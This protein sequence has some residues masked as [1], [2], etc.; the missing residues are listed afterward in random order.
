MD[1]IKAFKILQEVDYILKSL[2]IP[3]FF[4]AGTLLGCIRENDFIGHDED[5]DL[6]IFIGDLDDKLVKALQY[7][8]FSL[9]RVLGTKEQGLEYSFLKEGVQVDLFF[10]Y[11]EKNYVWH[12]SWYPYQGQMKLI[13][14]A[15]DYFAIQTT[16]FKGQ[17]F[18]I[19]NMPGHYLETVYGPTWREKDTKWHWALSPKNVKDTPWLTIPKTICLG[20]IVKNESHIIKETLEAV[21]PVIDC[22]VIVDT[23]ST[24]NTKEIIKETF[25]DIPG[26]IID[27]PWVN[28]GVNRSEV[29]AFCRDKADYFLTL[30]ADE[31]VQLDNF[32]KKLIADYYSV[33]VNDGYI[34]QF[35]VLFSNHLKWQSIGVTHEYWDCD[36]QP[37]A[38]RLHSLSI[39]H[40]CAGSRRPIKA[41]DDLEL[42]LK[43]IEQEPHN[44]RYMFYLAQTYKDRNEFDKA[45][46]WYKARIRQGGWKAEVFYSYYMIVVCAINLELSFGEISEAMF[47][48]YVFNPQSAEPLYEVLRYCRINQMYTMGYYLGRMAMKIPVPT[49]ASLFVRTCIYDYMI[50]DEL[51][52]CAYWIEHYAESL[53]LC[54]RILAEKKYPPHEHERLEKNREF[55]VA[56]LQEK[57]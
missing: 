45:I 11:K 9:D 44:S 36:R 57:K 52:I 31:I 40:K 20:M 18:P 5:I 1:K 39:I 4:M 24:D 33:T 7:K 8:G 2:K 14:Y 23:G 30:D 34:Y 6:G 51:S 49:N 55:C 38:E 22:W 35:P 43:G 25:K 42:L 28:F 54:N 41:N 12:G 13:K 32:N 17:D 50:M 15:F 10:Y 29:A 19:P 26:E 47:Q 21:K 3:Y 37:V 53:E 56:Q 46:Y 48:A 16:P 27:R